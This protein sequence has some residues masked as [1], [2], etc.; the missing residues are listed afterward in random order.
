MFGVRRSYSFYRKRCSHFVPPAVHIVGG[1]AGA[2]LAETLELTD[3]LD[4]NYCAHAFKLALKRDLRPDRIFE[5]SILGRDCGR[6]D[7]SG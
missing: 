3:I 1:G 2:D 4:L 7:A 6:R 5:Y